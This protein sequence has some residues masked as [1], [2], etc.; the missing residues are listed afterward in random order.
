VLTRCQASSGEADAH[1]ADGLA[2]A[3][4][5]ALSRLR[6]SFA[7]ARQ[8]GRADGLMRISGA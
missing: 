8:S 1:F 7:I 4:T 6:E 5:S 3:I 2:Q